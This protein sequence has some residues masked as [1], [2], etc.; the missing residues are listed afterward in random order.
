MIEHKR[1]DEKLRLNEAYLAEGQ[2]ISHTGSWAW[3]ACYRRTLLVARSMFRIFGLDPESAKPIRDVLQTL[4]PEDR[5]RVQQAFESAVA[6]EREFRMA[7]IAS[8]VRTG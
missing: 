3:N 1:A 2:R 7:S 6:R 4:H 8:F 5:S